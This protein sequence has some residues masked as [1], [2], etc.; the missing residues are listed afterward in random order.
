MLYVLL[1]GGISPDL[2][3]KDFCQRMKV[4]IPPIIHSGQGTSHGYSWDFRRDLGWREKEDSL[5][6][7]SREIHGDP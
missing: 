7:P 5:L 1:L 3:G 6:D 4:K 2:L